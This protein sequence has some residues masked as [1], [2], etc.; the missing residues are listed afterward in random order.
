MVF[1]KNS[2]AFFLPTQYKRYLANFQQSHWYRLRYRSKSVFKS[3]TI[4][5]LSNQKTMG[6]GASGESSEEKP[7]VFLFSPSPLFHRF[8]VLPRSRQ[9]IY[10]PKTRTRQKKKNRHL[11]MTRNRKHIKLKPEIKSPV[12]NITQA[13]HAEHRLMHVTHTCRNPA[14]SKRFKRKLSGISES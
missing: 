10:E 2:Q 7:A 8:R 6:E 9:C 3:F 4:V 11:R 14:F 1:R 5:S 12:S 13:E